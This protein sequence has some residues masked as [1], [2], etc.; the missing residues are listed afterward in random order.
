MFSHT[1]N[2]P[3]NL[4]IVEFCNTYTVIPFGYRCISAL[5]CKY[6]GGSQFFA[7]F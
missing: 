1:I 3:N 5:A 6:S 2:N 7:P 4:V